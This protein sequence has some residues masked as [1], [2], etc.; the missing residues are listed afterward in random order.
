[1]SRIC[2][3]LNA[4]GRT[5]CTHV[6]ADTENHC[7]A[8]HPCPPVTVERPFVGAPTV[9]LMSL[10]VDELAAR[11]R[12]AHPN[13]AATIETLVP[14]PQPQVSLAEI[15][16]WAKAGST[17]P[18]VI[19]ALRKEGITPGE[20]TRTIV[21][22]GEPK[23]I[24]SAIENGKIPAYDAAAVCALYPGEGWS[25]DPERFCF[26]RPLPVQALARLAREHA[27]ADLVRDP[28]DESLGARMA[29]E[30]MRQSADFL[31]IDLVITRGPDGPVFMD[32]W[33]SELPAELFEK[34]ALET[35]KAVSDSD[36]PLRFFANRWLKGGAGE[37]GLALAGIS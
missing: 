14:K 9:E 22:D 6:V 36:D 10:D 24:I 2:N 12:G 15:Q 35:A 34:A 17:N 30:L 23:T 21:V 3:H 1:M 29:T 4:D 13:G 7:R 32:E 18:D 28:G 27:A 20:V 5:R 11:A 37:P 25:F 33:D 19:L 8:G 16:S 26:E 31:G